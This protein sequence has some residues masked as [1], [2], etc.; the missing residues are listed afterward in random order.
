MKAAA[1][2]TASTSVS[3][4]SDVKQQ[5]SVLEEQYTELDEQY[6]ELNDEHE[7]VIKLLEEERRLRAVAEGQ[8]KASKQQGTASAAAAVAI[9]ELQTKYDQLKNKFR[10]LRKSSQEEI[11]EITSE[12]ERLVQQLVSKQLELA[13]LGEE[14]V[15]L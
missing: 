11:D 12:N 10:D 3:S 4:N 2:A 8:F 13:E 14:G 1:A 15:R 5:Y 9:E 7:A 6:K